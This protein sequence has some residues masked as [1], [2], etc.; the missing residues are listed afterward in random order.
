MPVSSRRRR[1]PSHAQRAQLR[2]GS[3]SW[4]CAQSGIV[5][6]EG[7]SVSTAS[8]TGH[9]AEGL[10]CSESPVSRATI[11]SREQLRALQMWSCKIICFFMDFACTPVSSQY[12]LV[13]LQCAAA[14]RSSCLHTYDTV[15]RSDSADRDFLFLVYLDLVYTLLPSPESERNQVGDVMQTG[16][17]R[18]STRTATPLSCLPL[19][20]SLM[21][22][23]AHPNTI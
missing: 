18:L 20:P 2:R 12:L 23:G 4:S 11:F 5:L 1:R 10:H 8:K 3:C 22:T 15:D 6:T 17:P 16:S 7:A 19:R 9:H 14:S 21:A 13:Y